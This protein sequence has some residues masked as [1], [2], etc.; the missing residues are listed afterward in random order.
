MTT[1]ADLQEAYNAL[2][3]NGKGSASIRLDAC[4]QFNP[5]AVEPFIKKLIVYFSDREIAP[6]RKKVE[7]FDFEG[8]KDEALK[9]AQISGVKME[10]QQS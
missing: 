8:A 10:S 6:I 4:N 1:F 5:D 9:L 3:A 2:S 7:Q